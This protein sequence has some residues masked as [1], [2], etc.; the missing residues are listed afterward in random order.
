MPLRANTE[1]RTLPTQTM[2][3]KGQASRAVVVC[4][5]GIQSGAPR[6]RTPGAHRALAESPRDCPAAFRSNRNKHQKAVTA[7]NITRTY[8][9]HSHFPRR[10]RMSCQPKHPRAA[11][12]GHCADT[13][14]NWYSSSLTS[15]FLPILRIFTINP[16][17]ARASY[18]TITTRRCTAALDARK[19]NSRRG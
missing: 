15:F 19:V 5:P 11:N 7:Q 4:A 8:T 2:T 1:S 17:T 16:S 10:V 6:R 18:Y 13:F 14:Y 3:Q 12:D 9:L